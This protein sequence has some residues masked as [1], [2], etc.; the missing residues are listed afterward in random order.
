MR[1]LVFVGLLLPSLAAA[2]SPSLAVLPTRASKLSMDETRVID[3]KISEVARSG[4]FEVQQV[5]FDLTDVTCRE[6]DCL[7]GIAVRYKLDVV[8]AAEVTREVG[9]NVDVVRVIVF[10][11]TAPNALQREEEACES[12]TGP[13]AVERAQSM[14]KRML[15]T[16]TAAKPP[17][18]VDPDARKKSIYRG[19]G[20]TSLGI[21]VAGIGVAAG[22]GAENGHCSNA[23]DCTKHYDTTAGIAVGIAVTG[24]FLVTTATFLAL[25]YKSPPKKQARL[26]VAPLVAPNEFGLVGVGRF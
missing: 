23:P 7:P 19:L 14:A 15:H 24:V 9:V 18:V 2:Q 13:R 5:S 4:G 8:A 12:C 17:L 1:T 3:A 22:F 21:A 20:F 16:E 26:Q 25:G 6:I 10:R 11:R